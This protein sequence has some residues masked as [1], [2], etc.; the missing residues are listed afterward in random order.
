MDGDDEATY[1]SHDDSWYLPGKH[2]SAS[3]PTASTSHRVTAARMKYY[4][5]HVSTSMWN[6]GA[7]V[8]PIRR[9]ELDRAIHMEERQLAP[10]I[11]QHL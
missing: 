4:A 6:T 7:I 9:V 8:S 5:Q 11:P 1:K 10:A 3:V 2:V